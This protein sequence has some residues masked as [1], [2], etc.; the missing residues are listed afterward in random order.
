MEK[1]HVYEWNNLVSNM[2]SLVILTEEDIEN[3]KIWGF[4]FEILILPKKFENDNNQYL[5]Q[6]KI[7][8]NVRCGRVIYV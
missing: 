4:G 3:E 6:L 8:V 1:F 5:S 2:K 7:L